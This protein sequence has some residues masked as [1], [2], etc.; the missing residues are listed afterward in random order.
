MEHDKLLSIIQSSERVDKAAQ[1]FVTAILRAHTTNEKDDID[2]V[3]ELFEL[4]VPASTQYRDI[5]VLL[6]KG[7]FTMFIK[8]LSEELVKKLTFYE[9]IRHLP[10][11]LFREICKEVPRI[12]Y[13][14]GK[15]KDAWF[16]TI[17]AVRASYTLEM[18]YLTQSYNERFWAYYLETAFEILLKLSV[19]NMSREI[20]W[21]IEREPFHAIVRTIIEKNLYQFIRYF[22]HSDP[23][24]WSQWKTLFVTDLG[25]RS[26]NYEDGAEKLF[27]E[28][29]TEKLEKLHKLYPFEWKSEGPLEKIAYASIPD[30]VPDDFFDGQSERAAQ[31]HS[32]LWTMRN[33]A[34]KTKR[35]PLKEIK[36][37]LLDRIITETA[38]N[39]FA[40]WLQHA[41]MEE[42]NIAFEMI[43]ENTELLSVFMRHDQTSISLAYLIDSLSEGRKGELI[44]ILMRRLSEPIKVGKAS[45]NYEGKL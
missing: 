43:S 17:D 21:I 45:Y 13:V 20:G 9:L 8:F 10:Q 31:L 6:W 18:V 39:L 12:T 27:S 16:K 37:S 1:Y 40:V 7:T 4:L 28:L 23:I 34:T 33:K 30:N 41:T 32:Y 19:N 25:C 3:Q 11:D 35:T 22:P 44:P 15:S 14:E 26:K 5:L 24:W 2:A 29:L 42:S 36:R 38:T